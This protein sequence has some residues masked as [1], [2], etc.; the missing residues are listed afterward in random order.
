MSQAI[1]DVL[2]RT[3]R[4]NDEARLKTVTVVMEDQQNRIKS[5]ALSVSFHNHMKT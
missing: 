4:W 3:A 1:E 5:L 2:A